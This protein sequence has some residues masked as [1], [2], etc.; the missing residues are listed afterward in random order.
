MS[1]PL[2]S[3]P[4]VVL[5]Q[6]ISGGY[7]DPE[8]TLFISLTCQALN[9]MVSKQIVSR[10]SEYW[11][12]L[13]DGVDTFSKDLV[14]VKNSFL[15]S[16]RTMITVSQAATILINCGAK[17]DQDRRRLQLIHQITKRFPNEE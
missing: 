12:S 1:F 14:Q 7:L 9:K 4:D 15:V 5:R 13:L 17:A 10:G 6:L 3:L 2:L 11:Q 8:S 16:S